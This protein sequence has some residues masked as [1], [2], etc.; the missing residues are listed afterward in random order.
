MQK[1]NL[2]N[3]VVDGNVDEFDEESDESHYAEANSSGNSN[4]LELCDK[5]NISL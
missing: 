3:D 5:Q 2:H 1:K 4:L